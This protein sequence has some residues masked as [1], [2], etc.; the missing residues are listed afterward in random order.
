M[1]RVIGLIA[2]MC[3]CH[4]LHSAACLISKR[5]QARLLLRHLVALHQQRDQAHAF[6]RHAVLHVAHLRDRHDCCTC[7]PVI[8]ALQSLPPYHVDQ[9]LL[10]PETSAETASIGC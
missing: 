4:Q 8:P 9:T 10:L 7:C 1:P 6:G 5:L 2:A 3:A